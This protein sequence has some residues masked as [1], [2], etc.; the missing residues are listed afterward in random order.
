M[1]A[2]NANNSSAIELG[3]VRDMLRLYCQALAGRSIELN[4]LSQLLE[5]EIGWSRTD[6]ATTDGSVIFLPAMID[7][8]DEAA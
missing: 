6:V 5:K 8:F 2:N 1:N 4:D 3:S 7:R